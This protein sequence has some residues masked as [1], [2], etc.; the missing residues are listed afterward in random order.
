MSMLRVARNTAT[1]SKL[2][3]AGELIKKARLDKHMSQEE[4]AIKMQERGWPVTR[5]MIF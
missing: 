4:L 3:V 1:N 2:T 5:E